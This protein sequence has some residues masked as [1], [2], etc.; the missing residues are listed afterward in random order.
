MKRGLI[1]FLAAIILLPMAGQAEAALVDFTTVASGYAA[2]SQG[3]ELNYSGLEITSKSGLIISSAVQSPFVYGTEANVFWGVLGNLGISGQSYT[4][5]GVQKTGITPGQARIDPNEGIVFTLAQSVPLKNVSLSLIGLNGTDL[6]AIGI[7]FTGLSGS[8]FDWYYP[9]GYPT[10]LP[11]GQTINLYDFIYNRFPTSNLLSS[12]IDAFSIQ[13]VSGNF[14]VGSVN[15]VPI[16]PGII[17]L[18]SGLLGMVLIS[19]KCKFN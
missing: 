2:G 4:G 11:S 7:K 1:V 15:V 9:I 16:P 6:G 3:T 8:Y 18:G 14:G 19:R 5:L 17:L 13:S 10:D 12:S